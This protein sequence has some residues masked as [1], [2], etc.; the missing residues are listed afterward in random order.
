MALAKWQQFALL[1]P[2]GH[3]RVMRI[4]ANARLMLRAVHTII[5]T[6]VL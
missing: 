4:D 2:S 3:T 1:S 5:S 6:Y